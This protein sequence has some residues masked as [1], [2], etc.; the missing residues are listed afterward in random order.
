MYK[1]SLALA[2]SVLVLSLGAHAQQPAPAPANLSNAEIVKVYT[3]AAREASVLD[4]GEPNINKRIA[5]YDKFSFSP[6]LRP[7]LKAIF[8]T[9]KPFAPQRLPDSGGRQH[10]QS[11]LKAGSHTEEQAHVAWSDVILKTNT[12]PA[13]NQIDYTGE[14]A[15]L[16]FGVVSRAQLADLRLAGRQSRASDGLWYGAMNMSVA[17]IAVK[18]AGGELLLEDLRFKSDLQ[19]RGKNVDL[20]YGLSM[21]SAGVGEHKIE[22]VNIA[23]R[24]LGMDGQ[25]VGDF[26][27]FVSSPQLQQL[28]P[29]AQTRIM[30]RKFKELGRAL[31]KGGVTV[32][33]DDISAAWRGQVAS[34]KG[35]IGFAR[36]ADAELDSLPALLNKLL[37]RLEVRVPVLAFEEYAR[38]GAANAI[39]A[40]TGE[41]R[42]PDPAQLAAMQ[43]QMSGKM[44]A[45][46][47]KS[48]FAVVDKNEVRTVIELKNGMLTLNGKGPSMFGMKDGKLSLPSTPKPAPAR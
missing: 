16:T 37:V 36:A 48:G 32:V 7:R 39:K 34:L 45:D 6:E 17:S 29:E 25:V 35:R 26:T 1:K 2:T 43:Q 19:R 27:R 9:D 23:T 28:A 44:L 10:Y 12:S 21:R 3:E 20:A 24:V 14:A 30:L 46:I 31:L 38:S 18:G 4:A 40:Q 5:A 41:H 33:I 15:S 8:G 47:G 42:A 13:G 11:I 22:R